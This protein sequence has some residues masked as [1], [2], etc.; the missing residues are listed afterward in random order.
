[1]G[2]Y[3]IAAGTSSDN[4]KWT[5]DRP[6]RVSDLRPYLPDH[7][8][9]RLEAAFPGGD[10]VFVWGANQEG[11]IKR[12]QRDDFV[13]DLKNREVVQVF[14]YCFYWDTGGETALQE[15]LR[16]DAGKKSTK[17][18]RGYRYVF[19]LRDP[20]KPHGRTKQF[21]LQAFDRAS[22]PHFFD[23][24]KYIGD[25]EIAKAMSR[26]N[27][28]TLEVF[29]GLA[30]ST[31]VGSTVH[32]PVKPERDET[33]RARI[34]PTAPKEIDD[35]IALVR[36]LRDDPGH[37][38]RD[39]EALVGKLFEALGWRSITEIKFQRGNIDIRI[40]DGDRPILAIEVKAD[41]ALSEGSVAAVR[42]AFGYALESGSRYVV[43]TNADRYFVYDR[44]HG[45]SREKAYVGSFEL[46]DLSQAGLDLLLR[47]TPESL[48]VADE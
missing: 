4:R 32:S 47:L 17:G 41:W 35:V 23:G 14:R 28:P 8:L 13:V 21:F 10:G 2:I 44:L 46:T 43:V 24:Q 31:P 18:R 26:T 19:F 1:M 38:E 29:L 11:R 5:L 15:F 7:Q 45:L 40:D 30:S 22:K 6:H 27:S 25:D 42:Q 39:H 48:R 36:V 3:F 12:V 34:H 37:L 16:W 20:R 9:E 33:R